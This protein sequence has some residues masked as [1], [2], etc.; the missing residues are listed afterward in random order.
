MTAECLGLINSLDRSDDSVEQPAHVIPQER[1]PRASVWISL[2][3]P[4]LALVSAR[5]DLPPTLSRYRS[6]L[7]GD[8]LVDTWSLTPLVRDDKE[9]ARGVS[10]GIQRRCS[11]DH[12][13]DP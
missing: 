11:S 6:F 8:T 3:P 5:C 7:R 2:L 12:S 10:K 13:P 4:R 1:A 9:T